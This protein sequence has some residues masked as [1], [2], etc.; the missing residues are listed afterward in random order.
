MHIG[1]REIREIEIMITE[2]I[3]KETNCGN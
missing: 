2:N 1:N 3:K